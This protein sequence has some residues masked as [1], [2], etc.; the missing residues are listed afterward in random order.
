[1]LFN[2]EPHFTE[3]LICK[4]QN[5]ANGKLVFWPPHFNG[6]KGIFFEGLWLSLG[7]SSVT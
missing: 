3:K 4:N 1:M 6:I 5:C 7:A 2:N